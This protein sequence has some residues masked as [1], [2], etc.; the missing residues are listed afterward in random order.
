MFIKMSY[1][2]TDYSKKQAAKLGL[3]IA[4]SGRKD[5]KLDA[6]DSKGNLVQSFG[7]TGYSD[8]PTY[9]KLEKEGKVAKGTAAARRKA[10]KTRHSNDRARRLDSRGK[11]TAGY[12]A[13]KILW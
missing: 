13:D 1:Q 10:Y 6:F 5:K 2:I 7:G 3:R 9:M 8:Y 11:L 12:L 4:P